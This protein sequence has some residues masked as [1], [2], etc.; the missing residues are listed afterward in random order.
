[1]KIFITG[2]TGY[3]GINLCK[4]LAQDGH[5]VHALCRSEA[6]AKLISHSNIKIFYGGILDQKSM[7]AGM[8][9]CDAA[10]HLA[11]YARVWSKDPLAFDNININGTKNFIEAA[12]KCGVK[13]LVI[14]STAGVFGPSVDD[15]LVDEKFNRTVG[16]FN[17]Y[18]R[19]KSIADDKA[20]EFAKA[21]MDIVLVHPT[22]VFGPG[23][24]SES[25]AVTAMISKYI[26][27]KWYILPGNGKSIGN[28]VFVDDVVNGH[29]LSM[30]KG[31]PGEKYILGGE[32]IS[33]IE[34]FTRLG[35]VS[36]KIFRLYK[37]PYSL[38]LALSGIML[39]L[40]RIFG[41]TP[42]ITPGFVRRYNYNWK[43]TSRKAVSELGYLITPLD[44]A[45]K[46]TVDWI[47]TGK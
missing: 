20:L 15:K 32:N 22:R 37:F 16:F 11:A 39:F 13:K 23:L 47:N 2:A 17:D 7:E 25:K 26:S 10:F 5:I 35:K 33:Y 27:G 29:I 28:Y 19:T 1:M 9:G 18:E 34:F 3:I 40:A 14:T 38:M 30:E 45:L 44:T 8:D 12:K 43:N 21:G 24:L 6:K 36:G 4:R 46:K 31:K 41:I 42:M